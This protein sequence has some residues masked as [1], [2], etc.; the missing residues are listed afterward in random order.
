MRSR[1]DQSN[2]D[3]YVA[4]GKDVIVVEIIMFGIAILAVILR[5]S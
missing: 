5:L 1:Y 2:E 3:V 4:S